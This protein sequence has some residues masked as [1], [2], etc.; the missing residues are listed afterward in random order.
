MI[1]V[2]RRKNETFDAL[3]R[4]FQRRVQSSGTIIQAKKIRFHKK[5]GSKN[6]RRE[7]AL[8]REEKKEEYDYLLKTGQIK[9]D[10]KK[11]KRQ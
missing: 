6:K 4:R 1:D 2:K 7:S 5:D 10:P 3:L 9:E 11:Q 8:F